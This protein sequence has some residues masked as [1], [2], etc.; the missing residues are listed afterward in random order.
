MRETH[1]ER[2]REREKE[3][4][5]EREREKQKKKKVRDRERQR[6]T[7]QRGN[8]LKSPQRPSEIF[9]RLSEILRIRFLVRN[10]QQSA[11]KR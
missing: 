3:R 7:G 10:D 2:K 4:K 11:E 6:G 5:R 9:K 8:G 1:R